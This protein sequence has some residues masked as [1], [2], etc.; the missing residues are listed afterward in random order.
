MEPISLREAPAAALA[1][2]GIVASDI[3]GTMTR[4]GRLVGDV[5]DAIARLVAAGIEVLPVSGRPAGEVLGLARYMPGV[6]RAVAE[7]GLALV[8]PG[9]AVTP[10]GQ[11]PDRARLLELAERI[12]APSHPLALAEDAFC[13]LCDVAFERDGRDD[14]SLAEMQRRAEAEG[15][16]LLWSSVHVHLSLDAPDK[17]RA[18]LDL[19]RQGGVDPAHVLTIGDAPNDVGFWV[20]G[21]FGL[22]VGCEQVLEQRA[23]LSQTPRYLVAEAADG[24]L[25]MA[26]ALLR[27]RA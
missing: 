3:D 22:P 7:N 4:D 2:V 15:I 10:L 19:C 8:V 21:R 17:G 1:A 6:R 23:V 24:W 25:E 5:M 16:H 18:V 14:A 20:P 27:A 11:A 13:R 12:A 9:E 26:E